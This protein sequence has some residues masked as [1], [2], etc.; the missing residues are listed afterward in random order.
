MKYDLV[1][2]GATG[3][4]GRCVAHFLHN[5]GKLIGIKSWAVSARNVE[6]VNKSLGAIVTGD[7]TNVPADGVQCG[8]VIKADST[9]YESLLKMTSQAHVVIACA[10]PFMDYG[11]N[12]IK[13]CVESNTEYVDITGETPWVNTMA[14]KYGPKAEERGLHILS[15]AAYDSVPSDLTVAMTAKLIAEAGEKISV[16]ETHHELKGGAMPVGTLNT[17]FKFILE[18]RRKFISLATLGMLGGSTEA[19]R[20]KLLEEEL[21]KSKLSNVPGLVPRDVKGDIS[22][23][24]LWNNLVPYSTLAKSWS[25]PHFMAVANVPIVH[26]TANALGYG[27]KKGDGFTYRERLTF[28]SFIGKDMKGGFIVWL[29]SMLIL[30]V[31]GVLIAP[32]AGVGILFFPESTGNLVKRF[33]N[34]DPGNMKSKIFRKLFD[35]YKP[36]GLTKTVAVSSSRNQK[37]TATASM[38]IDYDAGLGFTALSVATVAAAV[39]NKRKAGK[40]GKGFETV[41]A[42]IGVDEMRSMYEKAGVRFETKLNGTL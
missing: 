13:A 20:K 12:V 17:M 29:V 8:G 22:K 41:V 18:A 10:G 4:A 23:D 31:V 39:L 11:E 9:D 38:E 2:F 25:W 5:K 7:S 30:L 37:V 36:R 24:L 34:S 42:S 28:S 35:G 14:K 19:E 6:K 32:F 33:N 3:D 21:L 16:S 27:G 40:K 26:T 15:Q 1:V